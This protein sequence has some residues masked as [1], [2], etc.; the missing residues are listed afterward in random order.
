LA[1]GRE[2]ARQ[3]RRE[4]E[5]S[6]D[7]R[8]AA[9]QAAALPS[10]AAQK[11][12][13]WEEKISRLK[14]TIPKRVFV[15]ESQSCLI[16]LEKIEKIPS[17]ADSQESDGVFLPCGAYSQR[18]T[19]SGIFELYISFKAAPEDSLMLFFLMVGHIQAISFTAMNA[20]SPG[21]E[22]RIAALLVK[23]SLSSPA[24]CRPYSMF[25]LE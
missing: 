1:D 21:Y 4:N 18:E 14:A 20:S 17:A 22:R 23:K 15:D 16:C 10:Q 6:N 13:T 3:L 12:D 24:G 8:R 25:L 2:H 7:R 9:Q 5:A 11:A 19:V